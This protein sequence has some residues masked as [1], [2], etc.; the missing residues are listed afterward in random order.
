MPT[1]KNE[2]K[3]PG[4]AMRAHRNSLESIA[5]PE[6][7]AAIRRGRAQSMADSQAMERWGKSGGLA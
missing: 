7:K 2:K 6:Q 3:R 4:E 5:T 1:E